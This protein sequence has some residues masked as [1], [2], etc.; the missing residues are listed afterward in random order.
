MNVE[1]MTIQVRL[2]HALKP[3]RFPEHRHL[4]GMA[5]ALPAGARVK[6]L[7]DRLGIVDRQRVL[8][9][10]N[11]RGGIRWFHELKEGDFVDLVLLVGGG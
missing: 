6:D 10:V 8:V 7:F 2:S 4:E 3:E 9:N 1:T 11:R 5:L